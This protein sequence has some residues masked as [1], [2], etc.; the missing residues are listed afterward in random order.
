M[1]N[2]VEKLIQEHELHALFF[3]HV[4]QD[5]TGIKIGVTQNLN[6]DL[7]IDFLNLYTPRVDKCIEYDLELNKG[8]L[9]SL[10]Q[11]ANSVRL[12]TFAEFQDLFSSHVLPEE[13]CF[14]PIYGQLRK[15]G[16]IG[17]DTEKE[18]EE[19]T[20]KYTNDKEGYLQA[21][22][23][24]CDESFR[25]FFFEWMKYAA[26][27]PL[28][29][30]RMH[31]WILG[32]TGSGKTWL[33]TLIF[34]RL[35]RKYKKFSH[36]LLDVH[37]DISKVVKRHK[38]FAKNPDRLIYINPFLRTGMIPTFNFFELGNNSLKDK[39]HVAENLITAF[40]EC[41][42]R[43]DARSEVQ[44]NYLENCIYFLLDRS[45]ST[46][47]DLKDLLACKEGILEEARKYNPDFFDDVYQ[48]PTNRTRKSLLDRVSRL[49]NSPILEGL[50]G[51]Q[52]TF[53]LEW[54]MN[55]GKVIIFDL[56]DL[57]D[58]TAK[59]FGKFI[60]ASI[61]AIARK[62]QKDNYPCSTFLMLDE[63]HV[64]MSG[65]FNYILEQLRGFGL[66][67]ILSHQYPNQL[68]PQKETVQ[69]NCAIKI[70]GGFDDPEDINSVIRIPKE[71]PRLKEYEFY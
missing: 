53:D 25:E 15:R 46:I 40:E 63:A 68:G 70:A 4:D 58:M 52:S 45:G 6:V 11:K 39:I 51:G 30:L 21:L 34:Y 36:V 14:Y 57:S 26:L 37:G 44:I 32:A 43:D 54:A 13:F 24:N 16:K 65:T 67:T 18:R 12:F 28:R 31:L 59:I 66:H 22:C 29:M 64:L 35:V 23:E 71:I 1:K 38:A 9:S 61:K 7:I 33:L 50:F 5:Q 2:I 69:E 56:G 3:D 27:L 8:S 55:S 10:G 41:L 62:R 49:L 47:I 60:I 19:F 17:I 42:E 20:S 48:K